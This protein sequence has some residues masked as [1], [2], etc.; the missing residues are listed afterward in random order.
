[1]KY[2]YNSKG[3]IT[4]KITRADEVS[5][6]SRGSITVIDS[7]GIISLST[8]STSIVQQFAYPA[9]T[10]KA[11]LDNGVLTLNG[12]SWYGKTLIIYTGKVHSIQD[13]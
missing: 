10:I 6:S 7:S 3:T 5:S 1:M 4:L 8:D 13:I 9:N 2:V 12:L 11:S